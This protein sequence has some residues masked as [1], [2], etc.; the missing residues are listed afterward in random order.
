MKRTCKTINLHTKFKR[1]FLM[2]LVMFGVMLTCLSYSLQ[3][4]AAITEE[5]KARW[6]DSRYYPI[7]PGNEEWQKHDMF[8]TLD[9][10]NPPHDLLLS[11][12]TQELAGLMQEHP[13]MSQI[14]SYYGE[15]GHQN[16][17]TFYGF[18]EI[19]S[20]IFYE[21]L[22]RENALEKESSEGVFRL[23]LRIVSGIAIACLLGGGVVFV[24]RKKK[25]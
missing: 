3:V 2:A 22:R 13:L 11:M 19:N 23:P 9:I 8:A 17:E 15:D 12:S 21:L 4:Q 16:Y 5:V 1:V 18:M 6:Y 14:T 24:R 10:L 20:D 7:Y 25:E